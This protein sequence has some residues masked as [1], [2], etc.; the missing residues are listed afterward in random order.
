M[1]AKENQSAQDV[2]LHRVCDMEKNECKKIGV[3]F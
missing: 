3:F 2:S 1:Y